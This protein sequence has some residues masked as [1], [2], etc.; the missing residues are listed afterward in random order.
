[1]EVKPSHHT[2]ISKDDDESD[3]HDAEEVA[4]PTRT[5]LNPVTSGSNENADLNNNNNNIDNLCSPDYLSTDEDA[6]S[7][8][9]TE[10]FVER[11]EV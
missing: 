8:T 3:F 11:V 4:L 5:S 9:G 10:V 6:L 1:M 2:S 7:C